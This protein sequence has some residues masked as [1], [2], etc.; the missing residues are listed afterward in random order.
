MAK[1]LI[2]YEVA[3]KN[4]Y[5]EFSGDYQKEADEEIKKLIAL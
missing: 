4:A 3:G 5:L 1:K 2:L